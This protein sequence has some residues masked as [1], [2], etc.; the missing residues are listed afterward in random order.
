MKYNIEELKKRVPISSVLTYIGIT[1]V[2]QM[3]GDKLK[4]HCPF[5]N[6]KNPSC[7][8]YLRKNGFYCFSCGTYGDS[9]SLIQKTENVSFIQAVEILADIG[10]VNLKSG[11]LKKTDE[12]NQ[13]KKI[14]GFLSDEERKILELEPQQLWTNVG[15]IEYDKFLKYPFRTVFCPDE[16]NGDMYIVQKCVTE[17]VLRHTFET[18]KKLFF[19][20]VIDACNKKIEYWS[21]IEKECKVAGDLQFLRIA[22]KLLVQLNEILLRF[23]IDVQPAS[24]KEKKEKNPFMNLIAAID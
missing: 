18:D 10:G 8:V 4:I 6:D 11:E 24:E 19:D 14:K 12:K 7:V 13:S 9:L 5:H 23:K 15:T 1:P 20:I 17:D 3:S 16:K 22:Q 21:E 2:K